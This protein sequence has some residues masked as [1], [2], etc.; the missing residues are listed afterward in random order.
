MKKSLLWVFL[1]LIF[2]TQLVS[3]VPAPPENQYSLKLCNVILNP[4][5]VGGYQLVAFNKDWWNPKKVEEDTCVEWVLYLL[6]DEIDLD[7]IEVK[8]IEVENFYDRCRRELQK[9]DVV[10]SWATKVW[11]LESRCV[12]LDEC[13]H[14]SHSKSSLSWTDRYKIKY[15][16]YY[17]K[18]PS[19]WWEVYKNE[20]WWWWQ[21]DMDSY[22][23]GIYGRKYTLSRYKRVDRIDE[24]NL[25]TDKFRARDSESWIKK[26][27]KDVYDERD[28]PWSLPK[29]NHSILEQYVLLNHKLILQL[30]GIVVI[31]LLICIYFKKKKK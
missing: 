11:E 4:N 14:C 22:Y 26:P 6:P 24:D 20:K 8:D 12:N 9:R 27:V 10:N 31:I 25:K 16:E 21:S 15:N 28:I 3:A 5:A 18:E 23:R 17:G 13:S 19:R 29:N 30:W 7:D 1:W 2:G